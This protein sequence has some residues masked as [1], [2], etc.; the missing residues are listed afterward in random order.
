MDHSGGLA[1]AF[2]ICAALLERTRTGHGRH[3]DLGL[4]DVQVSMLSYLAS[5]ELN[6]GFT[7]ARQANGSHPS[8]VPA[9]TFA[10]SDGY[11]SIFVGNDPMWQRLVAAVDDQRVRD[12]RFTRA[13]DRSSQ[14]AVL[15]PLLTE[16]FLTAPTAS[17]VAR[18]SGCNVPCAPV[19]EVRDALIDPQT[20]A[21]SLIGTAHPSAHDAYRHAR[22]PVPV[23]GTRSDVGSP[24]VGQDT[25]PL[26]QELGYTDDQLARLADEG[27]IVLV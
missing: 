3:I 18:L 8:I 4:F 24:T 12:P 19:N 14:R 27:V 9:Q 22:G 16:V 20:T 5:W 11:M 1:A 25:K 26:M 17:W 2:G 15:I 13:A 6:A 23:L 21:R 7:P 10:T